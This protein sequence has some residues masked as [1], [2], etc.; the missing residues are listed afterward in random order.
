MRVKLKEQSLSTASG[1]SIIVRGSQWPQ[2]L[3]AAS[4]AKH[5]CI[6]MWPSGSDQTL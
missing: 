1:Y 4:Q 5:A 3:W 6:G 2:H